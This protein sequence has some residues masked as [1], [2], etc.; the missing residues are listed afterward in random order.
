MFE[1]GTAKSAERM[2]KHIEINKAIGR[3]RL[4]CIDLE[5]FVDRVDD[6]THPESQVDPEEDKSVPSLASI[7][8]G[9]PVSVQESVSRIRDSISKLN[10]LL[11]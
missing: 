8:A 6:T 4:V 10:E 11:F 7:L 2:Q 9:A 3:L 5:N 1:H